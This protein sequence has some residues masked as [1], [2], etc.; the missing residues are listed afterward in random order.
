VASALS[1]T[2]QIERR[3]PATVEVVS[4]DDATWRTVSLSGKIIA[5][6]D[7]AVYFEADAAPRPLREGAPVRV[8][9]RRDGDA[10]YEFRSFLSQ[11]TTGPMLKI[12]HPDRLV[13][14]QDREYAR[15]PISRLV[16]FGYLPED[17]L[18]DGLAD[19]TAGAVRPRLARGLLVD[20]SG[21]GAAI[22]SNVKL[23][24]NDLVMLS[25]D[26]LGRAAGRDVLPGQVV[27]RVVQCTAESANSQPWWLS[28]VRFVHISEEVRRCVVQF[29]DQRL[30]SVRR[31]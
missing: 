5:S 29:V 10:C 15:A 7:A 25:F 13:R 4:G 6:T 8:V 9:F 3:T 21:G 26:T 16:E 27:G 20:L 11:E 14:M 22:R 31:L 28:R 17:E 23:S 30:V 19:G 24:S 18:A 2:R 1:N 12:R